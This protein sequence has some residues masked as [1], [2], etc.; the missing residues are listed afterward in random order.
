VS[1]KDY[2]NSELGRLI[3]DLHAKIDK[4]NGRV[5][6]QEIWRGYITGAVAI[7]SVIILPLMF[8]LIQK[9]FA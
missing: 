4:I 3:E 9:L 1:E 6:R 2:T 7:L 5:R 8:I